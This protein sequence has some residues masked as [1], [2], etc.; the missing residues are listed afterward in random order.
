VGDDAVGGQRGVAGVVDEQMYRMID[1]RH[2]VDDLLIMVVKLPPRPTFE[3]LQ[4]D[5]VFFFVIPYNFDAHLRLIHVIYDK[6][7][8]AHQ[9]L[10]RRVLIIIG[11]N[12]FCKWRTS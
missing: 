8:V 10:S 11:A 4:A 9:Q 5:D 6:E 2:H 1:R 12:L 3:Q 7:L